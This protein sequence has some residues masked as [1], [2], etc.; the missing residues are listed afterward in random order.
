MVNLLVIADDY[1]GAL[2]T[3]VQF[4]KQGIKT[5]VTV[6]QQISFDD[7]PPDVE[8][9]V[10]D[11]ESRHLSP[12]SAYLAVSRIVQLARS[13]GVRNFYKKTDSVLR[14]NIGAELSALIENTDMDSLAFVPAY[15]KTGRTVR[16]GI[17][18]AD[19]IKLCDSHFSNDLFDPV[20]YSA[21]A[22]I[23]RLQSS[24]NIEC[25]SKDRYR[26]IDKSYSEKTICVFDAETEQDL[27]C[28]GEQLKAADRLS[29][30]AGCAG[31]AELLPGL[32]GLSA[33]QM[34][35]P[36]VS[37][38][39]LVVTA[40]TNQVTID[41]IHYAENLDFQVFTLTPEQKLSAGYFD[42]DEGEA[43][44]DEIA[45]AFNRKNRVVIESVNDKN[46][47]TQA[48]HAAEEMGLSL[49]EARIQV[50]I[51]IGKIT[52]QLLD[53]TKTGSLVVFGGDT[54]FGI[55]ENLGIK[56]MIP[57]VEIT[58]GVAAAKTI[59]D[60]DLLLITK[61]G[62]MGDEDVLETIENFIKERL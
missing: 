45:Q 37:A 62:G 1:T 17:L 26:D 53:K 16:D 5:L 54:L 32:L 28:I 23:I 44:T 6:D 46:Q 52:K 14:G 48:N 57:L 47:L 50:Q 55:I 24:L 60:Y 58:P 49:E 43:F 41:Q 4:S 51:N 21:V 20:N 10:I 19:G 36:A 38:G 59:S 61:S 7:I 22:D 8:V 34:D 39:I 56:G 15:P 3:G 2:D 11:L 42:S 31:F 12:E 40:S 25:F 18:Y 33:V 30:L 35:L 9:L 13:A 29:V 27:K